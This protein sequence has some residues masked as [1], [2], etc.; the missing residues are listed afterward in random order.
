MC[1]HSGEFYTYI[2]DLSK[3]SDTLE[4]G[5]ESNCNNNNSLSISE[6]DY[7][8]IRIGKDIV[9]TVK[10]TQVGLLLFYARKTIVLN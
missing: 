8:P 1:R 3:D 5:T 4:G 9:S 6:G 10:R 2:L 7:M